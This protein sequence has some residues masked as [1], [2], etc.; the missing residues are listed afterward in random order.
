MGKNGKMGK[1]Y[2]IKCE[3]KHHEIVYRDSNA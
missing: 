3:N 2:T 1:I